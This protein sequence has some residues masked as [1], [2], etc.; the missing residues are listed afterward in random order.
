MKA[1]ISPF[2]GAYYGTEI[3]LDYGKIKSS[4]RVWISDFPPSKRQ[5]ESWGFKTEQ[6]AYDNDYI[7]DQHYETSESYRIAELIINAI[8]EDGK[9]ESI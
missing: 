2:V 1:Y 7:C 5:L 9:N 8:N 4:F 6:E 3:I